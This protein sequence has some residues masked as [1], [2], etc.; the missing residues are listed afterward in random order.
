MIKQPHRLLNAIGIGSSQVLSALTGRPIVWGMPLS[1]SAELTNWCNLKCPECASGSGY[2]EREK[3]FM[4]PDLFRKV[5]SELGPYLF[6]INLYFQGES[7]VHPRFFEFL[8]LTGKIRSVVSTNGH[9]LSPGNAEKLA[10]SGLDTL[11]VSLDGLNQETYSKYRLGGDFNKVKNG[12]KNISDAIARTGSHL[13][14]EIQF[15]VN[16]YNE[17]QLKKAG[18][19]ATESGANLRLKSMQ[20]IDIKKSDKWMPVQRRFRRYT[21]IN[22]RY[23]IKSSLPDRCMRLWFNPVITW[24]GKVLPCCFDKNEEFVM[25]DLNKET[26]SDIWRGKEYKKF[27]EDVLS[28]RSKIGICRN[29]T[30]GLYGVRY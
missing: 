16:R 15:L 8:D 7:M 20:V 4:N 10:L 2:S 17:G 27:R 25:G 18:K 23:K 19:F 6:S 5:L 26:F 30:A 1:V 3:G 13:K 24:N 14:L 29:C 21:E 12:I 9:F 22:G 28:A 11:I